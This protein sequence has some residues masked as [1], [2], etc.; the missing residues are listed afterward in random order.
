MAK[1]LRV[2]AVDLLIPTGAGKPTFFTAL[3]RM[4]HLQYLLSIGERSFPCVPADLAQL[5]LLIYRLDRFGRRWV[6]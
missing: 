5:G 3:Q 2:E 6:G 1:T 4:Q